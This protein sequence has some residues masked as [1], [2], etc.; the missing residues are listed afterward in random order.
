M[1]RVTAYS[2]MNV[3]MVKE[4]RLNIVDSITGQRIAKYSLRRKN[5]EKIKRVVTLCKNYLKTDGET[6]RTVTQLLFQQLN[7]AE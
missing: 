1:T 6:V 4:G 2:T 5:K 7:F 3:D